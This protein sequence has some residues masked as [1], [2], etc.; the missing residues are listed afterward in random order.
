MNDREL[1]IKVHAADGGAYL[2]PLRDL[3]RCKGSKWCRS[4]YQG[5]D[6]AC[7]YECSK[8]YLTIGIDIDNDFCSRA[9]RI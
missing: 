1:I 2:E 9:E 6:R 7:S 8:L 4:Y 5:P 3:I